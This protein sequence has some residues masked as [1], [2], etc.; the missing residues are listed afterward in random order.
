MVPRAAGAHSAVV[1][2]ATDAVRSA[3][4]WHARILSW[5]RRLLD[6]A[7]TERIASVAAQARADWDMIVH[8]ASRVGTADT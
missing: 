7:G 5:N 8:F 3:R 2:H 6:L 4:R 1:H